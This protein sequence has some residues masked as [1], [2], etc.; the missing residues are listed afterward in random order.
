MGWFGHLIKILTECIPFFRH[1]PLRSSPGADLKHA[2]YISDLRTPQDPLVEMGG[3]IGERENWVSPL[4]LLIPQTDH[5]E[6]LEKD[7]LQ[8][9]NTHDTSA[10]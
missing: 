2:D 1:I 10:D 5:R 6:V 4:D 7:L 9:F 3:V 8:I